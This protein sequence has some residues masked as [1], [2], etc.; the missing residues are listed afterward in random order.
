MGKYIF[1]RI[2]AMVPVV[3]LVTFAVFMLSYMAAGDA[4][5]IITETRFEHPTAAQIEQIRHEEGLDRPLIVQYGTWLGKVLHGDFGKSYVSK[6]PALSELKRRVPA[7]AK[8]A[9][10]AL[11]LLLIVSIPLG[12]ISAVYEGSLFDR[13]VQGLSFFSVSMPAFWMG[14]MLLY[15]FGVKLNAINVIGGTKGLPIIPALAMD[16]TGFGILIRMVRTNMLQALKKDYIRAEKAKGM[17]GA[18]IVLKHCLKNISIPVTTRLVSTI[19]GMFC[20][21]AIIEEIFSIRGIGKMALD[22]VHTKDAPVLECFILVLAIA[23]VLIN[24]AVDIL[25]SLIDRRIQ[26]K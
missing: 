8:L 12:V 18:V 20:G 13:I 21:S 4:A 26:L 14:L 22:A 2:L 25:Y 15:L 11:T 9:V 24:L 5:R 17:S 6:K 23:V 1:K 3:L 19:I 16:A 7:T 10:T